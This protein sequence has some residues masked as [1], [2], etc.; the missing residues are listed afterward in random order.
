MFERVKPMLTIHDHQTPQQASDSGL[1]NP[2]CR[3]NKVW[4]VIPPARLL[5]GCSHTFSRSKD[6]TGILDDIARSVGPPTAMC[7]LGSNVIGAADWEQ[8]PFAN[9]YQAVTEG[10]GAFVASNMLYL[11]ISGPDATA[12][13]NMLTPRDVYNL[14][15]GRG[16]FVLFTTP[17]GTV[18]EE[19]IVL[20]TG[21]EEYLV[22]CGGGKTPS[23]LPDALKSHPKARVEISDFVSFNLKGPERIAAMQTLVQKEYRPQVASLRPFQAC[24]IQSLDGDSIWVLRTLVG[25][26]MWSRVPV[27]RKVWD[28]ILK[29]PEHITPC[30]WNLL[31]VYRMECSLMVFAVYPL[32]VHCGTTLWE[33]G[34]GWMIEKGE[35]ESFI[36]QDALH[37]LK[38]KER[39]WLAGLR[40]DSP[41]QDVLPVGMEIFNREGG[42][43]GYVTSAAY[44]IKHQRALAFAHLEKTCQPGDT[45]TFKDGEDWTICLL[46]FD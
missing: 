39:L 17:A 28:G 19:A 21:S 2:L 3:D 8:I 15:P 18:D 32:D 23:F 46:P 30:G 40:A 14:V 31:N 10:A 33:T 4:R 36:G 37:Q 22:S 44:S 16:M 42:V 1:R 9:Q 7:V 43:A 12:L 34:Y 24:H 35:E 29:K 11:R 6:V 20:K 38:G 41:T 26:E 13:L 5:N 45:L 25:I 27:I